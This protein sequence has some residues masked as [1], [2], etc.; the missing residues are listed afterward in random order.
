[1]K[2]VF[3]SLVLL[4]L[5]G[6]SHA[7]NQPI[8]EDS[9]IDRIPASAFKRVPVFLQATAD[10]AQRAVLPGA[11]LFGQSVAFK[12]REMLGTREPQMAEGDSVV[13]WTRLSGSILV[14]LHRGAGLTWSAQEWSVPADTIQRSSMSLLYRA[15]EAVLN[16]GE[17]IQY[18]DAVDADSVFF[19]LSLVN[20][21][22]TEQGKMVPVVARH[23][24]PIFSLAIPWEKPIR[25]I[26]NPRVEYPTFSQSIG[27]VGGV[28]VEYYV[29]KSGRAE[30][31]TMK[32]VWPAGIPKPTGD[33]LTAYTEFLRAVKRGLPSARFSP[34]I[35]GG[36]P[37]K[38]VVDHF[39]EFKFR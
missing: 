17:F 37:V 13:R 36:C 9:C 34:A 27:S 26:K 35:V 32:E 10:S 30:P 16:D 6:R 31:Q 19:S 28:R 21:T 7:Q 33:L 29:D 20:P 38:K 8:E 12:I 2:R 18:P 23:P 3:F 1:M 25:V 24:I 14:T 4:L 22:V 39:F 11:E 15:V 5:A